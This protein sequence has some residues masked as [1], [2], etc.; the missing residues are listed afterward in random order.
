MSVA[1]DSLELAVWRAIFEAR[2]ARLGDRRKYRLPKEQR[3]RILS[4]HGWD[5]LRVLMGARAGDPIAGRAKAFQNK[6]VKRHHF[7]VLQHLRER[8]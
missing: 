3:L 2:V 1:E 7:A 6:S 8:P 5:V 4:Y